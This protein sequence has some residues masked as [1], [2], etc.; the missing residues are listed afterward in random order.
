MPKLE[1]KNQSLYN[2]LLYFF[3]QEQSITTLVLLRLFKNKNYLPKPELRRLAKVGLLVLLFEPDLDLD[4][5]IYFD[6]SEE[7]TTLKKVKTVVTYN[8]FHPSAYKTLNRLINT[9]KE[10][11][12][13]AKVKSAFT[14]YI[15]IPPFEEFKVQKKYFTFKRYSIDYL[16]KNEVLLGNIILDSD[17]RFDS[18]LDHFEKCKRFA[19][20]IETFGNSTKI[21]SQKEKAD[22][23]YFRKG[24][25]RL[26]QV[27]IEVE[28]KKYAL[29]LD[30]GGW[31]N[32]SYDYQLP[33]CSHNSDG[34]KV[35]SAN[36]QKKKLSPKQQKFLR[37]LE[38]KLYDFDVEVIGFNLKF[39]L[40]YTLHHLGF[41][42]NNTIDLFLVSQ[43]YWAGI[44]VNKALP[45]ADRGNRSRIKH[46]LL[47]AAERLG[48]ELDK[49]EQVSEWGFQLT[50][51]QLNYAA[52]DVFVTLDM[53]DI[54]KDKI[55]QEGLAFTVK[56]EFKALPVFVEMEC[57]GVPVDVNHAKHLLSLYKEVQLKVLETWNKYFP[58]TPF[59]ETANVLAEIKEKFGLDIDAVNKKQL[60]VLEK[61]YPWITSLLE[62][63]T[64]N[65]SINYIQDMLDRVFVNVF[66]IPSVASNFFQIREGFRS[67]SRDPNLQNSPKL[68]KEFSK[69]GLEK[70]QAVRT[71]FA[72][73]PN[74]YVLIIKDAS[75]C[76]ARIATEASQDEILKAAYIAGKDQHLVT[77]ISILAST[78]YNYTY[79]EIYKIHSL[80]KSKKEKGEQLTEEDAFIL[81]ARD[82]AKTGFYSFLNQAGKVTMQMNFKTYGFL[83]PLEECAQLKK[84][85]NS[86][87]NGLLKFILNQVK[88]A[89]SYNLHFDFYDEHGF[90]IEHETYGMIV[91]I[92]GARRY[93]KKE[94]NKFR[95]DTLEVAFT[96]TIA[97]QWLSTEAGCLKMSLGITR[98]Y[99]LRNGFFSYI[100]N[101]QHDEADIVSPI[102]EALEVATVTKKIQNNVMARFIK[103]IPVDDPKDTPEKSICKTLADK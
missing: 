58:D 78:G 23:L 15:N 68:P 74:L 7:P 19:Y 70:K 16:S 24:Y 52:S 1:K 21:L 31:H 94:P 20:D 29:I 6:F 65:I 42:T 79:E 73:D 69:Y 61:S 49:S 8:N 53:W 50:N 75:G 101:F 86:T 102:D 22:A 28:G 38:W 5:T 2:L 35:Y 46:N 47:S 44:G 80:A 85:L 27:G 59:T 41:R 45:G 95:E 99:L 40:T 91:S 55:L 51:S 97:F 90:S 87:Y 82:R 81:E 11:V 18:F 32:D 43:V 36:F 48:I 84:A 26:I 17:P 67:S 10:D 100:C 39:D 63:R 66:G 4:V 60:K 13:A 14:I 62:A 12:L 71:I 56:A 34:I 37:I 30:L 77:A 57:F 92:S 9:E 25:I 96:E 88:I 33:T 76:H 72:P 93:C 98:E 89:N 64:L 103:S 54:F 3:A 83:V